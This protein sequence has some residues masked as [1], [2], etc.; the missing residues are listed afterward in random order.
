MK[1]KILISILAILLFAGCAF[2]ETMRER[3][4]GKT[5]ILTD[6]HGRKYLVRHNIGDNY[7]ISPYEPEKL[8]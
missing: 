1:N 7:F 2:N 3:F 6:E 8:K 5:R 4:G